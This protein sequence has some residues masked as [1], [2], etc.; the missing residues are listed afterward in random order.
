M[1]DNIRID[2]R[3]KRL[4]KGRLAVSTG[5]TNKKLVKSFRSSLDK[6]IE[7]GDFDVLE[8]LRAGNLTIGEI[9]RAVREGDYEGLRRRA[10]TPTITVAEAAGK[11]LAEVGSTLEPGTLTQYG[12]MTRVLEWKFPDRTLA[13]ITHD[14]LK[15]LLRG[16]Q[17][18]GK[19]W[20]PATVRQAYAIF[21][22][23]W[24]IAGVPTT[25][26]EGIELPR[27]RKPR[28][29]FLQPAEWVQLITANEGLPAAA[30]IALGCLAGLRIGEISNLRPSLDIDLDRGFIRIQERK[31]TFPWKP[32]T[33][34]ST[35]NV[36]IAEELMPVLRFHAENYAGERYFI[37]LA[38]K[39][40]PIHVNV[41]GRWTRRAMERAGLT[42]GRDNGYTAHTLRHTFASWLAQKDVQLLKIAALLGDTPE[43]VASVYA[44]LTPRDLDRAVDVLDVVVLNEKRKSFAT[45]NATGDNA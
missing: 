30:V 34:R 12:T 41:L 1:A 42:Y 4:T 24:K 26:F 8:G 31:G 11:A 29:V 39:D 20:E 27:L 5:T 6:L 9:D 32:K 19:E 7:R 18:G 13:S 33:D 22:R 44:H 40:A 3:H 45:E 35:R 25:P 16:T 17:Q 15:D 43:V 21:R 2:L 10:S 14:E 36:P 23:I 37:R 28:V 38:G